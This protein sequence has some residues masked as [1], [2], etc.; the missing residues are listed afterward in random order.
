MDGYANLDSFEGTVSG[1]ETI[2]FTRRP[3]KIIV[4]NDSLLNELKFRFNES[5]NWATLA[6]SESTSMHIT[7]SRVFLSGNAKYRIWGVG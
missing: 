5:H 4:H 7:I 1:S 6:P 2:T 3:R